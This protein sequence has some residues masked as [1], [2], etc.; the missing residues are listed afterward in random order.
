[1]SLNELLKQAIDKVDP[2]R[3]LAE[4]RGSA[5]HLARQHG[6]KVEEVLDKV[7]EKIDGTTRGKYADRLASA[8]RK[9]TDGVARV[10][11]EPPVEDGETPGGDEPFGEQPRTD[12]PPQD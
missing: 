8:R 4:L 5:G 7:E 11:A 3:R 10:A 12:L 9:V 6:G 2:D 1:M